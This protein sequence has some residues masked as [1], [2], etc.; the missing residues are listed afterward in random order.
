MGTLIRSL[1]STQAWTWKFTSEMKKTKSKRPPIIFEEWFVVLNGCLP[2]VIML[3]D[4]Q[5]HRL[6]VDPIRASLHITGSLA[7]T[8]LLLSLAVTPLR[9]LTGEK[10][11]FLYRRPLGLMAFFYAVAHLAIFVGHDQ[12]WNYAAIG[13]ELMS[14]RYLQ[15]GLA[16][17]CLMVPLAITSTPTMVKRLSLARWKKL[18]R[19]VYAVAILAMIHYTMQSKANINWQVAYSVLLA[20]LLGWR[21]ESLIKSNRRPKSRPPQVRPDEIR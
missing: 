11:L 20:V 12:Q 16:S 13:Q 6:G 10:K 15:A 18:H 21:L 3:L 1:V 9:S 7:M 14:R 17:I 2:I 19:L 8:S 5:S 4:A